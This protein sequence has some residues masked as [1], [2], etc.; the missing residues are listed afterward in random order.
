[1][2]NIIE[3]LALEESRKK[4]A[5]REKLV[6]IWILSL[7]RKASGNKDISKG[8]KEI[9]IE[10]FKLFAAGLSA[11]YAIAEE[12]PS[13]RLLGIADARGKIV[14]SSSDN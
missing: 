2:N 3:A 9:V 5:A 10:T 11:G 8:A 13:G 14:F 4:I 1:M 7:A 12:S 6:E